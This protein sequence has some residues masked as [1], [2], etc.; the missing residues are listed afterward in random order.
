MDGRVVAP[1]RGVRRRA[2]SLLDFIST[3]TTVG[4]W[5]LTGVVGVAEYANDAGR[6]SW[7][8][9]NY[10]TVSTLIF[11]PH[12]D[13]AGPR[14][15]GSARCRRDRPNSVRNHVL[16]RHADRHNNAGRRHTSAAAAAVSTRETSWPPLCRSWSTVNY[17]WLRFIKI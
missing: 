1:E 8:A 6:V 12:H 17:S 5:S 14:I 7:N 13:H 15:I 11:D 3:T 4:L 2:S 16:A 10:T 9:H